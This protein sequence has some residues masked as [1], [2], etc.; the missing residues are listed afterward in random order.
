[1]KNL[2][3]ISA[4]CLYVF[5]SVGCATPANEIPAQSVSEYQYKNYECNQISNEAQRLINRANELAI[6]IN[7]QAS[8]DGTATAIGLILFWPALFFI[9][10]DGPEALEYGRIKGEYEALKKVSIR[11]DCG[12]EFKEII[13]P[14]PE[15]NKAVNEHRPF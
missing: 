3:M 6:Q 7:E 2:I 8:D 13:P 5:L 10:G 14:E 11:K 15:Q 9:D 12:I 4:S 1:M